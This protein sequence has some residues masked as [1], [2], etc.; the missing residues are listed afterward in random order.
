[1]NKNIKYFL[2]N[3]NEMKLIDFGQMIKNVVNGRASKGKYESATQIYMC[4]A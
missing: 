2:K 3:R 4:D 1:M